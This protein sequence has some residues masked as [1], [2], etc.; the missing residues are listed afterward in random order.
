[1]TM[2]DVTVTDIDRRVIEPD[3]FVADTSAFVDVR[4]EG[5]AGKAS[6]SFIGPGVSQ[7]AD[8]VVNLAE[9]HGFCVGAASMPSGAVNNQHMH[10]TAEVFIVTRGQWQMRLGQHGESRTDI[11]PDTIFS[12]PT[13]MFRGFQNIG[14]DDSW[15]F[16]VLGGNDTGGLLWAPQVLEAAAVTGLHLTPDHRVVDAAAGDEIDQTLPPVDAARLAEL[17]SYTD[18][19]IQDRIVHADE[20]QWSMNALLSSVLPGH[21]SSMA[22]VIGFGLTEDRRQRPPIWTPHGFTLEWLRLDAGASTGLHRIDQAQALFLIDGDWEIRYNQDDD[23]VARSTSAGAV[24]SVP[25]GCWR[26]IRNR[27]ATAARCVVVCNSDERA[28]AQWDPSIV[29]AAAELGWGRDASGYRAPL[30]LIAG[31]FS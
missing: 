16:S 28:R 31:P 26:E 6:Y 13:W 20:L 21:G 7:N 10:Y 22:P 19:E 9:P 18:D 25:A 5:S 4:L 15:M 24:V 3:D 14:D 27:G 11:G 30:D 23:R 2:D 1:M 17:D 29:A 12:I 8:Q